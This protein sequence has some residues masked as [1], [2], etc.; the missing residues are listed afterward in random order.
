MSGY[1]SKP[2]KDGWDPEKESWDEYKAN[3]FSGM[4]GT[5]QPN[6]QTN[7]KGLCPNTDNMVRKKLG[8]PDRKFHGADA[9]EENW[10]SAVRIEVKAGKQVGPIATRFNKAEAQ[11]WEN[12]KNTVGGRGKPFMM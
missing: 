12:V 1:I 4:S 8:I 10:R 9:H 6:S 2:N 7:A 5:G 11:S 3:R